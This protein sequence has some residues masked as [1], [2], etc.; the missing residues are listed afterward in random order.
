MKKVNTLML[1]MLA[2]SNLLYAQTLEPKGIEIGARYF[3]SGGNID[4]GFSTNNPSFGDPSSTIDWKRLRAHGGEFFGRYS[5]KPTGLFFKGSY[6]EGRIV[7]GKM[8]DR[9]FSAGQ[10]KFS[11]MSSK[12]VSGTMNHGTLDLGFSKEKSGSRLGAFVGYQFWGEKVTSMGLEDNRNPGN[13][14]YYKDDPGI[15][16]E[17]SAEALRIGID[18]KAKLAAKWSV[19]GEVAFVP[20]AILKNEDSHLLR[21]D[22]HDLGPVPNVHTIAI[23]GHGRETEVFGNYAL[24]ST[25]EVGVG[26][27][28]WRID[29]TKGLVEMGVGY[30]SGDLR[31]LEMRRYGM[32]VQILKR[33]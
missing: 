7:S 26:V 12:S 15:I 9:D 17:P 8:T 1:V 16:Y 3:A 24:S 32:V 5:H 2:W 29:T 30:R 19:S 23:E 33:F 31:K 18:G 21:T 10:Y 13:I 4:W 22:L 20:K 25:M 27:R 28:S 14:S 11:D 6:G